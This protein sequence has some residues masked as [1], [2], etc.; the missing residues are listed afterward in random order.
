MAGKVTRA[1]VWMQKIGM[2][3]LFRVIQEPR[4]MF[5]RYLVTNSAFLGMVLKKKLEQLR[6]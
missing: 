5:R 1:P 3:W 6:S 4:R 2:E